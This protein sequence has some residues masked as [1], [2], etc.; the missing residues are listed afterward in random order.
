[1]KTVIPRRWLPVAGTAVALLLV[2]ALAWWGRQHAPAFRD[3]VELQARAEGQGL[4]CQ[5]DRQDGRV[6]T[7]LA[8]STRPLTWEELTR[9]CPGVL[10]P[11]AA[12]SGV[13][14]A[15]N[16]TADLDGMPAPPWDG[17]CRIWGGVLVTGDPEL[18]DRIE[19]FAG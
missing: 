14:W 9:L 10:A 3:V 2:L 6:T 19:R 16:R 13:A 5:S 15:V 17:E 18:L 8:I 11:R 7:A 12:G 1:M 4:Y